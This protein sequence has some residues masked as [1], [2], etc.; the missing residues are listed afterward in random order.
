MINAHLN[1]D[2]A[3]EAAFNFYK[4]ALGGELTRLAR[5]SDTP[6]AEHMPE[7]DRSKIMHVTLTTSHGTLTGSDHMEAMG[8]PFERGNDFSLV[9]QTDS[10][11][12]AERLF[13]VLSDGGTV[14]MP[15]QDVFWGAYFGMFTDKFGVRWMVNHQ[16]M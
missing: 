6:H 4:D 10:K 1:F 8:G 15:I 12:E 3:T 2:G 14:T 16:N 13:A 9:V 11:E 5:F 7:K